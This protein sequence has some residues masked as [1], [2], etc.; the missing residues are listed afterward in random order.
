MLISWFRYAIVVIF[1]VAAVL[2]PG[3][4]AASQFLMATPLCILYGISIGVAYFFGRGR[5]TSAGQ[6]EAPPSDDGTSSHATS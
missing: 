6:D 2:T 4:D 5:T 3:P 1:I